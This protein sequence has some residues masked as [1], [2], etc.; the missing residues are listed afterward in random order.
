MKARKLVKRDDGG[1][2][3]VFFN[4]LGY[5]AKE[6]IED[7]NVTNAG[8]F[9]LNI[10]N[11]INDNNK[12][13]IQC[14]NGSDPHST[15]YSILL[16]TDNIS[17]T[18]NLT[19]PAIGQMTIRYQREQ[20]VYVGEVFRESS[21]QWQQDPNV[22]DMPRYP[23]REIDT[24]PETGDW[25]YDDREGKYYIYDYD[26]DIWNVSTESGAGDQFYAGDW[27]EAIDEYGDLMCYTLVLVYN[28]SLNQN[29]LTFVETPNPLQDYW[30]ALQPGDYYYYY[31]GH[32]GHYYIY[33]ENDGWF[34]SDSPGSGRGLIVFD[35][36]YYKQ[37]DTTNL[38]DVSKNVTNSGTIQ[39]DEYTI[40]I[41]VNQNRDQVSFGVS[42]IQEYA[43]AKNTVR[44]YSITYNIYNN[45]STNWK[46]KLDFEYYN[47]ENEEWV[48]QS[49]EYN[50]V[51]IQSTID[52]NAILENF[53]KARNFYLTITTNQNLKFTFRIKYLTQST[54]KAS[55][56]S[57]LQ[58]GVRD[59][60]IA[61]L[62]VI[63]GELWYRSSYGLPLLDK[64]KSK[65]IYDSIIVDYILSHPDVV[66]LESFNSKID[67]H[68]Y[69]F[70]CVINTIY[71]EKITLSNKL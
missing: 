63:K 49:N 5:E 60:L 21:N 53:N 7:Q 30:Y 70:D 18:A 46:A 64:I 28:P 25:Y 58:E 22:E 15:A 36:A 52:I 45:P 38:T 4:S 65:G 54:I 19:Y 62:S 2:N 13:N 8:T 55:N 34:T 12:I 42:N 43:L 10:F 20:I 56:Y 27:Y 35:G 29:I 33:T 61:R 39:L 57:T 31:D 14:R 6:K 67:G 17:G 50:F 37:Y 23:Y 44:V 59:S 24:L 16:D 32:Y 48:S 68:T 41:S 47:N 40:N 9:S 26:D 71:N 69:S 66:N 1:Y 51:G 11:E 3:I